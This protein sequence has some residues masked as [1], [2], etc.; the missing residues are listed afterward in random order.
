M[1]SQLGEG[2]RML[3]NMMIRI[4]TSNP[5]TVGVMKEIFGSVKDLTVM[6]S[7]PTSG[8]AL[9]MEPAWDSLSPF[10]PAPPPLTHMLALSLS[11]SL[12]QNK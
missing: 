8:W 10:L 4:T 12:S 7:S 3:G 1:T 2:N 9:S 5:I 11:L 6:G